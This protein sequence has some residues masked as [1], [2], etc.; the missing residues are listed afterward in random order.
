MYRHETKTRRASRAARRQPQR[1]SR[2]LDVERLETR[3]APAVDVLT[4]HNDNSLS[5]LNNQE[6]TLNL[7]NLGTNQFGRLLAQPV[8]GYVYAE[9][10]VKTNLSIGGGTHNAVFVATQGDSVY[11][12]DADTGTQY[13]QTSLVIP[14]AGFAVST[15]PSGDTGSGDIVPQV[16][17]TGTPVIGPV[18]SAYENTMFVLAKTKE[19]ENA[20]GTP[21]YIFRLYALDIRNGSIIRQVT[22]GDTIN[23]GDNLI[24]ENT[25]DIRV[26]GANTGRIGDTT[27]PSGPGVQNGEFRFNARREH[28]RSATVLAQP[29][30]AHPNGLIYLDF[31]SHGDNG[32]YRGWVIGY[33]PTNLSLQ[34]FFLTNLDARASGIWQSGSPVAIEHD[35]ATNNNFLYFAT[36]NA[37]GVTP[38]TIGP[39]NLSESVVRIQTAPDGQL[40]YKDSFIPWNWQQLDGG[41][42]DLG[43]GG[44]ALLPSAVG[45]LMPNGQRRRLIVETGKEGKIYLLDRDDLG[46]L[47]PNQAAETARIRDILIQGVAGV[48]GS[49][50]FVQDG[51]NTG[52]LYYHG[53]GD[54]MKAF[55]VTDGKFV[56]GPREG[57]AVDRTNNSWGFPGS[58]PSLTTDPGGGNALAFELQTN[59]YAQQGPEVLHIYDAHNLGTEKYRS[60]DGSIGLRDQLGPSTKFVVPTIANGHVYV[61]TANTIQFFGQFPVATATPDAP[62]NLNAAPL[63]ASQIKLTWNPVPLTGSKAVRQIVIERSTDGTSFSPIQ[64]VARDATMYTDSGLAPATHY[65]YQIRAVNNV[66]TS[67]PSNVADAF[68][69][70]GSTTVS[71]YNILN[72]QVDLVWSLVPEAD[73]GYQIQRSANGGMTWDTVGAVGRNTTFF[74]DTKLNHQVYQYRVL[75]LASSGQVSTSNVVTADLSTGATGVDYSQGF[76]NVSNLTFNGSAHPVA[77]NWALLTDGNGGEAGTF[78]TNTRLGIS[79]F[80]TS[81]TYRMHDGTDPRADGMTFIIQGNSPTAIGPAGGGLAYGSDTPGGGG[82]I[83]NSAAIKFDLYNNAGEGI[84][85]TGL[86]TGG[87]SPTVRQQGLPPSFPDISINLSAPPYLNPDGTPII[88]INDQ[89]LKQVDLDYD[90]TTL[91]ETITDLQ[92]DP[93]VSVT[94]RYMNVD[95]TSFVGSNTA[96]IGFGGGTG[97]LTVVQEIRTWTYTGTADR[98]PPP[99]NLFADPYS[100]PGSVNLSWNEFSP[101]E[102]GFEIQRSTDGTNWGPAVTVP[103][104]VT[105]YTDTP[106]QAGTYFYRV[107]ALGP[108]GN[109]SN[110][111][112]I[113]PIAVLVPE[114][115]TNLVITRANPAEVDLQWFN[116]SFSATGFR[117]ERSVDN[118]NNFQFLA[119]VDAST[120]TYADTAV[121]PPHTYYYRVFAFNDFGDSLPS[122]VVNATVQLTMQ[123]VLYYRFDETGAQKTADF[124]NGFGST[125][126]LVVNN[127]TGVNVFPG[128][129]PV[130]RIT[131]GKNGEATSAW[132]NNRVSVGPF[133]TTFT[134]RDVPNNG[135]ADSVSFVMQNDPR[136]TGALGGG[137]GAGGYSGIINSFA[138]KFDLYT[139]GTHNPSTGLFLNGAPPDGDPSRD[140]PLTGIDLGSGHPMQVT[141]TYD[142]TNLVET[143]VDMVTNTTFSHTYA[144]NLGTVIGGSTAL[145]G[146]TGATGGENATQDIVNWT[147][148]FQTYGLGYASDSSGNGNTGALVGGVTHVPSL[149]G[150]GNALNFN[151]VDGYVVAADSSSL[152]TRFAITVSAW[153]NAD[154]WN[155]N[156]RLVQKGNNDNEYRLLAEGGH[157]VFDLAG[158]GRLD[159][160]ALPSTGAWHNV[161]GTYDGF[162]MKLYVDGNLVQQ[163]NAGGQ[164]NVTPDPL[165]IGTKNATAPPGDHFKGRMDEVRIYA[166]ALS[167]AEIQLLPL[168][169]TDVGSV[170]TAGSANI[171]FSTGVITVSGSGHDIWDTQDHFN[172]A[173]QPL[174]GDG[175]IT[176]RVTDITPTDYWAKAA[177][178]FRETLD[179]NSKDVYLVLTPTPQHSEISLQWRDS[180]GGGPGSIDG[181]P[182]SAPLPRWIRL[183]RRGNVFTAEQSVD[184]TTWMLFGTHTTAMN[185]QIFVGLAVTSHSD[186]PA[187]NTSHFD[188]VSIV[189][190]CDPNAPVPHAYQLDD[191][192]S[193][194]RFNNSDTNET[195]DNWVANSFQ[196]AAGGETIKSVTFLSGESYTNRPITVLI[197]TGTSLTDPHAGGGLVRI[198]TTDTTFSGASGTWVTIPLGAPV[199]LPVGQIYWAAILLRGVP[200]NQFP[201]NEDR[202]NPLGRSWFDVGGPHEGDPYDLNNTSRATVFGGNHPVVSFAQ[203]AGNLMLRVIAFPS[204]GGGGGSGDSSGGG[205]G[206][207]GADSG[208]GDG[209]GGGSGGADSGSGGGG[210]GGAGGASPFFAGGF[211]GGGGAV[212]LSFHFGSGAGFAKAPLESS[213]DRL[214]APAAALTSGSSL[215]DEDVAGIRL[216][217]SRKNAVSAIDQLFGTEDC[218]APPLSEAV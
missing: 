168:T 68:T 129:P 153:I 176:A 55:R 152:N 101:T 105:T 203:D 201:L 215:L 150:L 107:R 167:Q 2:R 177:L 18:G 88:N 212:P 126:N 166:R 187:L 132:Y 73:V 75:A 45:D 164:I 121:M 93:S 165:Y 86:F 139:H 9:P 74:S 17:I 52:L 145:V 135:A 47:S 25:T 116:N 171:N 122:N 210:S 155:G 103:F 156:R 48:W 35:D 32:N 90:G 42:T 205:G 108:N 76:N 6:T 53:S 54:W 172:F 22:V 71:V 134:L 96:Y 159:Q 141:L 65:F 66:G 43:S 114:A 118:P 173:Y 148:V 137:G 92:V 208:S 41:D 175:Q 182:G 158:V 49:P 67:D 184:G 192:T 113:G 213:R 104:N 179:D 138:V 183:T 29:D 46:G 4:W 85:S 59:N 157:L 69:N 174:E 12:F 50:A 10:L 19:V 180:T 64:I 89:H 202:D 144:L 100:N 218:T 161:T 206:S 23:T 142:G 62:A 149:T 106:P 198:S 82:G 27:P 178:M 98:P 124:G 131:D 163:A 190:I 40:V 170:P 94:I 115:P 34:Q 112:T 77:P 211:L 193:E 99:T 11:A 1:K 160:A 26:T 57:M 21:H 194:E 20:S 44:T 197:Y 186:G 120:T 3:L 133:S 7:N 127:P 151:G 147:G 214:A 117:I 16:G 79:T 33:D 204:S 72:N 102:T 181:G 14:R 15:V 30:F 195:E 143:V 162:T 130:L 56:R 109:N 84:N 63:S 128:T 51:P 199:T 13:W 60:D 146:F 189:G 119:T 188:N 154:D 216:T 38:S 37:F 209:G 8:D 136:G 191:G 39:R 196:V 70:L 125:S 207:G 83:P 185:R 24:A 81:F 111:A 78:F 91:T 61:G 140:V 58:Q 97:G 28:Q 217:G 80:H 200:G 87:R 36:G 123:A 110:Y 31:A 169:D 5:G 95:L